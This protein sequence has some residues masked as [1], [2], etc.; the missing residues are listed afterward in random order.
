M[1]FGR[2]DKPKINK[3]SVWGTN[4]TQIKLDVVKSVV[5]GEQESPVKYGDGKNRTL[6]AWNINRTINIEL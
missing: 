3:K 5:S 6:R 2:Q 4:E 1:L